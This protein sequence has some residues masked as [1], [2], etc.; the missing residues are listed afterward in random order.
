MRYFLR[1]RRPLLR[2][3]SPLWC[4]M[5]KF[6][7][8]IISSF[9]QNVVLELFSSVC[10][11]IKVM[12]R[13]SIWLVFSKKKQRFFERLQNPNVS[14]VSEAAGVEYIFWR[15]NVCRG[16]SKAHIQ[17]FKWGET[18]PGIHWKTE[19]LKGRRRLSPFLNRD[20]AQCKHYDH[21]LLM[22]RTSRV[23]PAWGFV[24][25]DVHG[26]LPPKSTRIS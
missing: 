9:R 10:G 20:L 5:N 25:A 1:S 24:L 16:F 8:S 19:T 11:C 23:W 22:S 7:N 12:T 26:W 3:M 18:S 6:W 17:H 14:L 21:G 15:L 4:I 2:L 13:S